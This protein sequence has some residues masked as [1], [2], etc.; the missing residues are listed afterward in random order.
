MTKKLPCLLAF[1]VCAAMLL[2]A[3]GGYG[4]NTG[5]TGSTANTSNTAATPAATGTTTASTGDKIGVAEC[6]DFIAKY[7]A[8]VNSKVPEVARATVKAQLDAMRTS[9]RQAATTPQGKAGLAQGCKLAHDQARASMS[10]YNC[11]W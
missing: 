2:V 6:D 1:A 8:C 10:A 11:S 5:N 9:W 3:C 7:E 4:S